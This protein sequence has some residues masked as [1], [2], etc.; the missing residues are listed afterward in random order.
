[1][2]DEEAVPSLETSMRSRLVVSLASPVS[3]TSSLAAQVAAV[4]T[5]GFKAIW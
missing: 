3:L 5:S 4:T 2:A 1:M